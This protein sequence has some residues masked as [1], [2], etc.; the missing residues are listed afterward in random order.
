MTISRRI[1]TSSLAA[2]LALAL[3]ACSGTEEADETLAGEPIAAIPAPDGQAWTEMVTVT[4]EDGYLVGNPN[5][6]IKLIEYASHTC[7]HCAEFSANGSPQLKKQYV[8]TGVVSLELRNLVRDPLDLTIAALVR[9]GQPQNMMPLAD[10]AW[11][12]IDAIFDNA[13]RNGAALEAAAQLPPEQRFVGIAQATGLIDFF[14]ARGLS[15]EQARTCLSDNAKV[16]AIAARSQQQGTELNVT[17]TPTFF[18]NG[19]KLD[20][21]TWAALEPILQTAGAR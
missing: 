7:G 10:Q 11:A 15:S 17:G 18:L 2:G 19:R 1:L 16:E 5:A 12:S 9:C 4:P 3:A 14:A 20:V 6:P 21:N 13:N 8:S